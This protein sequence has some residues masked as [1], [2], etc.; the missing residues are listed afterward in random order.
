MSNGPTA[1]FGHT[2]YVKRILL[3]GGAVLAT[4]LA[5]DYGRTDDHSGAGVVLAAVAAVLL[6]NLVVR[7][8]KS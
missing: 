5:V 7:M 4:G 1:A 2:E 8:G 6:L 3:F